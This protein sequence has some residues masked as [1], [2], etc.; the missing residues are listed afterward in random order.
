DLK[1]RKH[2]FHCQ[3]LP[4]D[5]SSKFRK[6]RPVGTKLKFHWNTRYNTHCE[7]QCKDLHPEFRSI[8]VIFILRSQELPFKI[9]NHQRKS[10]SE[11]REQIMKGN[12][13]G[14]L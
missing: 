11:L 13:K 6:L 8:V 14:K 5:S 9:N 2:S 12:R 10:H 3:C 1:E 4:D 7:I